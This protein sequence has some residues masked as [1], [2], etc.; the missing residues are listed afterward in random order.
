MN[1]L[2]TGGAGFI[3]SH[4]IERLIKENN[5]VMCIDDLS[6][7]KMENIQHL[8]RDPLFKFIRM[9]ILDEGKLREVFSK[10]N[11]EMVFHLAANSDIEKSLEERDLDLN[12]NFLTTVRVL[13]CMREFKVKKIAFASTS[14]VY[15][16]TD[17]L[18]NEDFGPL[19]P[20]SL[21]GA[22]KLAAEA[23][24]SVYSNNYDI[25]AWIFR[26][27]NVVGP[28][29]THGIIYD[30]FN[31]LKKDPRQLR[32]LGNGKQRKPY[33]HVSELIDA[34][35]FC[36]KHSNEKLNYFNISADSTTVISD[37][38]EWVVKRWGA[39]SKIIYGKEDRGWIGDVS[40]FKYDTLKIRK[41]GWKPSLSSD[42]AIKRAIEENYK[43]LK[44]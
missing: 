19:F 22:T 2:I 15:G 10:H 4:L 17:K 35:L 43:E 38:A 20:I 39:N 34:L 18:I 8:M 25:Q 36:L 12:K 37:I 31:K 28:R 1:I 42:E 44:G 5:E 3:G 23:Y 30:L 40:H 41:L 26:F 29:P 7:G 21:Y 16:E 27:P 32:V 11:F 13:E 24:I 14:A 9:D 6:L 33:L